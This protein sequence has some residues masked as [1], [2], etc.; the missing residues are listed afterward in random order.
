L[1]HNN[2]AIQT[3]IDIRIVYPECDSHKKKPIATLLLQQEN[4]KK[5]K[6]KTVTEA[7][8]KFF[9]PFVVTTDGIIAKEGQQLLKTVGR[10]LAEK[11]DKPESDTMAFVRRKMSV[12]VARAM[13][14]RIRGER[15]G[16]KISMG[17]EDGAALATILC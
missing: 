3:E 14:A 6:Y 16:N 15:R 17:F 12:A 1:R 8:G 9:T 5:K 2:P 10:K 4:E 11:W 13:S 7:Q